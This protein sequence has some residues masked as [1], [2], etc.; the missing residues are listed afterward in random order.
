MRADL[1]ERLESLARDSESTEDAETGADCTFLNVECGDFDNLILEAALALR[2][3]RDA[4]VGRVFETPDSWMVT[5]VRDGQPFAIG[6]RVR[7]V[8]VG[9]ES[10]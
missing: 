9:E 2:A 5:P 6:R 1:V 10:S 7:L 3:L 4:P 8:V